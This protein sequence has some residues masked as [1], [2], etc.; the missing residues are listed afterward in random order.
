MTAPFFT[1]NDADITQLEGV[2]IKETLPPA[3]VAAVS[4]NTIGV[5]G[6]TLKGPTTA[7]INITSEQRFI[8]VFGGGYLS[9]VRVNNVWTSILNKGFSNLYVVRVAAAAA[10]AASFT[11]ESA[12]GGA[13]TAVLRIDASSVGA[14]GNSVKWKVV[15]AT[16]GVSTHFNLLIKDTITGKTVT[17]QNLDIVAG[18]NTL[19][20]VGT[21]DARLVIL[22]KLA[23]ARPSNSIASTDGAD[24]D[25][26]T[27]LGQT[28]AG[29]TSVA[30]SDGSVADSDYFG[31]GT[32]GLD[33]LATYH[34][35]A[36][37][38]CAE[39]TSANLKAAT[40]V[41]AAASSDRLF[42]V[43]ATDQTTSVSA[44]VTDVATYRSDR[45]I[46]VYNHVYTIDPVLGTE[47]LV[48]PESWMA[49]ILAN[50][51]VDIHVG[52]E[53][54]KKL[55]VGIT[56]IFQPSLVRQD[57][58][59]LKAAGI[60]ALEID[61][62]DPVFVSGVVTDLTPGKT[63]IARRRMADFLQLSA[64]Q[65]LRFHVKKKNTEQRRTAIGA[66]LKGWLS[67]LKRQGRVVEDFEI[68]MDILTSPDDQANGIQRILMRVRLVP[69]M[70][71]VVLVTQ[72]GT[73][74]VITAN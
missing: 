4:L 56:R 68:D 2:Y 47:T 44:A 55:I 71:Y 9:G 6:T 24:T 58:I 31:G 43:G 23:A 10:V 32:K 49:T 63:E 15:A 53:D 12:S 69:H 27:S 64:A 45:I 7:P 37:V 62:G 46:Y 14:W 26:Y 60:S 11:L 61:L 65:A 70:L 29:Y 19:A 40:K 51:D 33:L 8:D 3:T 38:Y 21:D 13:G 20:T 57:Y 1:N 74:V 35:V 67:G 17:Y 36:V 73:S 52:E 42:L 59:N 48:R 30:G 41:F 50:T 28:V 54:T 5:F 16:D 34:G 18:D 22:T 39:Y 66:T 25:G 72:I